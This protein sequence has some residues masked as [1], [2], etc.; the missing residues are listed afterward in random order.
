MYVVT[1][2]FQVK[3]ANAADFRASV[4]AQAQNSL[5]REPAC[6]RFDV[7]FDPQSPERVFLYEL[8]DDRAA[9]D[10]HTQTEHFAQFSAAV[11]GWVEDKTLSFWHLD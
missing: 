10:A 7:C 11:E 9:F 3:P 4:L 1:V 6:K 8:Y 5:Q 2:V